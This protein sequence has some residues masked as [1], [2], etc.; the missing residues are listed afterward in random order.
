MT[1]SWKPER[2]SRNIHTKC[3]RTQ[4]SVTEL[5]N[6]SPSSQFPARGS[7][8]P[9]WQLLS[10]MLKSAA[11]IL[12][13][14]ESGTMLLQQLAFIEG[15]DTPSFNHTKGRFL[16]QKVLHHRTTL[17]TSKPSFSQQSPPAHEPG[18]SCR[19]EICGFPTYHL[20]PSN[21]NA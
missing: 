20:P 13:T 14:I 10:P 9:T 17:D 8:A 21:I 5:R 12:A 7:Q 3:T 6:Y 4:K 16:P 11:V 2:S 1:R 15:S 18:P 19:G